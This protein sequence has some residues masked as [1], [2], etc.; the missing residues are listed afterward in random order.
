MNRWMYGWVG[1]WMDGL[2]DG[3]IK[4]NKKPQK[5]YKTIPMFTK[6]TFSILARFYFFIVLLT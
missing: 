1:R 3:Q 2:M 5:F 4:I 6:Y